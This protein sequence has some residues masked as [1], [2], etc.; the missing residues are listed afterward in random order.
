MTLGILSKQNILLVVGDS[1]VQLHSLCIQFDEVVYCEG[2]SLKQELLTLLK[3]RY[4]QVFS[5]NARKLNLR[6][7]NYH[8][9]FRFAAGLLPRGNG[10]E[11]WL[12]FLR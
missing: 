3:E 2:Y 12:C 9:H 8:H 1:L 11:M 5:E 7:F 10:N 4:E 6:L